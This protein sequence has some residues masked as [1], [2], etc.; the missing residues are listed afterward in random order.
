MWDTNGNKCRNTPECTY[1]NGHITSGA[2]EVTE[3]FLS[4]R[5]EDTLEADMKYLL[6]VAEEPEY[7]VRYL[8]L[9]MKSPGIDCANLLSHTWKAL[10]IN[11]FRY[12]S[13]SSWIPVLQCLIEH[14]IDIH[15]QLK[16][17]QSAYMTLVWRAKHPFT[18]DDRAF[19]WLNMLKACG[20]DLVSYV[21][22]E[23]ELIQK[24]GHGGRSVVLLDYDGL[25][26]P[27]WRWYLPTE[28]SAVDGLG[29]FANLGS[30][31]EDHHLRYS[32]LFD[33]VVPTGPDDIKAW[34]LGKGCSDTFWANEIFP[35]YLSPIDCMEGPDGGVVVDQWYRST[36]NR[37]VEIRD[38]RL[39]RRQAKK[40]RKAHPGERPPSDKMPGTW[41]D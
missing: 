21:R 14:G 28:G 2:S 31:L 29:E 22:T 36:Y 11:I 33:V 34:K 19:Q 20:V 30:E 24:V 5:S 10:I 39:A 37:A 35:F 16:Y 17:G 23:T 41:V 40:W 27:S 8:E 18:A 26:I 6:S 13:V 4:A 38:K 25:Q 9:F 1:T 32:Y 12:G 15:Q 3:I 7:I